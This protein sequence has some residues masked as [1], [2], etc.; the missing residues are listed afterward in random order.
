MAKKVA[1]LILALCGAAVGVALVAAVDSMIVA[2]GYRSL[3]DT[4]YTWGVALVYVAAGIFIAI[5][6]YLL[7]PY[8]ITLFTKCISAAEAYL[9]QMAI[10]DIFYCVI[11]LIVGLVVAF[12]VS[13][14]TAG[15]QA[16]WLRFAVDVL[17]YVSLAYLG[18]AVMHKRR[19]ELTPPGWLAR[20]RG[21][22]AKEGSARPKLLDTSVII[23]GRIADIC[24]TGI[25][26]GTLVV[27]KFVLTELQHIAD[28]PDTLKRNRGRR[29]LDILNKI[30]KELDI[31]VEISSVDY[32]DVAEVD[33]KLLRMAKDMGGMVVTND[34]NL[35]KV[36][37]VQGV[38]VVNINDLSN[39]VKPVLLPGE[40]LS[41]TILKEGKENGQGIAYLDDGTMMVV[42]NASNRIGQTLEVAVTSV[43][44][45]SAGRMIFAKISE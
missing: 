42:E 24:A 25:I 19:G 23:D 12:L 20:G 27:P 34:F 13:T 29:G 41:V 7:S 9:S 2:L 44:Q 16:G 38:S 32:D 22:K 18:W 17:L 3:Y 4:M 15:I 10:E 40:E 30:Q 36:A 31:P 33:A 21:G 28:S 37:A 45:T 6:F 35:N 14:L 39:A 43:L 11:G 1:R 26:E 5:I 8:P